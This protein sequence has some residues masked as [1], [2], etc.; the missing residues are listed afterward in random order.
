MDADAKRRPTCRLSLDPRRCECGDGGLAVPLDGIDPEIKRGRI[1]QSRKL[2][3]EPVTEEIPEKPS[4]P[5]RTFNLD[6]F[7]HIRMVEGVAI[8]LIRQLYLAGRKLR[9][10]E[11]AAA[12]QLIQMVGA[13]P[14]GQD[15]VRDQQGPAG[16]GE[17]AGM[18]EPPAQPRVAAQHAV[19]GFGD[20]GAVFGADEATGAEEGAD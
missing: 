9:R 2:R 18:S 3:D 1:K 10:G 20:G 5:V 13:P 14:L 16:N 4:G 19:D 15:L 6:L 12:E 11:P 17:T 7:R 8:Q